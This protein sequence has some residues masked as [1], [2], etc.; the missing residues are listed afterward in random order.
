MRKW[1]RPAACGQSFSTKA[2]ADPIN[3]QI[4]EAAATLLIGVALGFIYDIFRVIRI[5]SGKLAVCLLAD[6][7][8]CAVAAASLF[9]LGM[10]PGGGELRFYMPVVA[11]AGAMAYTWLFGPYFRR[12]LGLLFDAIGKAAGILLLPVR[13][14]WGVLKK[15]LKFFKNTFSS[16]K[17]W[18]TITKYNASTV[19]KER[20]RSR[21]ARMEDPT[22]EI[23]EVQHIYQ[24]SDS[25]AHSVRYY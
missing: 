10:G 13:K 3:G 1:R 14:T 20:V 11:F 24:D 15:I 16:I 5:R 9:L 2:V 4:L 18:F 8:F 23:Q 6:A 7:L 12:G 25:G 19:S 17:K 22:D 21:K